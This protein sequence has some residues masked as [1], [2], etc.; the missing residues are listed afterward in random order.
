MP[1]KNFSTVSPES[2]IEALNAKIP[3]LVVLKTYKQSNNEQ[4]YI[5]AVILRHKD[6]I[7]RF[8]FFVVP[9]DSPALLQMPGIKLL[10]I[11]QIIYEV[12]RVQEPGRKFDFQ[13]IL[14][15]NSLS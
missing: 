2:K 13:T 1:S 3:N 9:G 15:F 10:G 8:R 7:T 12:V 5:C 4:L 11:Q 6:K 14:P